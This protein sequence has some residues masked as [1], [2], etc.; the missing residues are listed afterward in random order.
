MNIFVL[1]KHPRIAAR[2]QCD[3]H[4]SKMTV[5][6]A[7]ML[8]TVHRVLSGTEGVRITESGRKV[9][10]WRLPDEREHTLYKANHVNH[11]C[12]EWAR[13]SLGNF[14]W[15]HTHGLSLARE[16][17]R[18]YKKVHKSQAVIEACLD[19]LDALPLTDAERTPHALCMPDKYKCDNVTKAYRAFYIG[20]KAGFAKWNKTSPPYW[21]T[22]TTTHGEV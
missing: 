19:A 18:R 8:S 16:Y 21:W 17:T 10:Y 13:E 15:L 20:E 6:T 5:E 4:V 1:H 9:K 12:S 11:P 3:Q 22:Q 14:L 2:M 7:Q